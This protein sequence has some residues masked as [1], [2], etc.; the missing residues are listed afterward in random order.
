[1]KKILIV[2]DEEPVFANYVIL[3]ELIAKEL[4][5]NL[6]VLPQAKSF[7]DAKE[8]LKLNP[9]IIFLDNWLNENGK[10][11]IDLFLES[12]AQIPIYTIFVTAEDKVGTLKQLV[13]KMVPVIDK[14]FRY[15][16]ML[17]ILSGYLNASSKPN[18][19]QNLKVD[20]ESILRKQNIFTFKLVKIGDEEL[21]PMRIVF[22]QAD[23]TNGK[24]GTIV[25]F[26]DY[27]KITSSTY[28]VDWEVKLNAL[29]P[30]FFYKIGAGS[31][32]NK[33]FIDRLVSPNIIILKE[34]MITNKSTPKKIE[35]SKDGYSEFAKRF[36]R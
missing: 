3:V 30:S 32:V 15:N 27:K 7:D 19:K 4:D 18:F 14:P 20:Y 11:G 13:G 9:D 8:S 17:Q 31:I 12:I 10:S 25:Y 1:M 24:F 35:V 5:V 28:I 36:K 26:A 2:E 23:S 22:I 34:H 33:I 16:E 21:D 29:L 6:I